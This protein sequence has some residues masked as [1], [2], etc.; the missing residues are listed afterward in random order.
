[1]TTTDSSN[2]GTPSAPT[3]PPPSD[4]DPSSLEGR[5]ERDDARIARYRKFAPFFL[6]FA[7]TVLASLSVANGYGDAGEYL[8]ALALTLV[9]GAWSLWMDTL[10]PIRKEQTGRIHVYYWVRWALSGVLVALNPW[11]A[12][13]AFLGY[14]DVRRFGVGRRTTLGTVG[15][16]ATAA[17]ITAAQMG[18]RTQLTVANVPLYLSLT[19]INT[20]VASAIVLVANAVQVQND[21]RKQVIDALAVTNARLETALR[22]NTGLHAQLLSQARE[23]GVLAERQRLAG[24]IHDTIAQGLA[25]IV[26][27]LGA[28]HEQARRHGGVPVDWQRHLDQARDLARDSLSEARRSVEALRPGLLADRVHLPEAI[29]ELVARWSESTGT[30]AA[31]GT[32][33]VV[34]TLPVD[35]EVALFRAAQEALANVAKHAHATRAG[36][37]LTYLD[38]VVLLDVRD[39]GVGPAGTDDVRPDGHGGY[40]LY[41]MRHRLARVGGTVTIEGAP[42]EG[43]T[44]NVSVP[45]GPPTGRG[46]LAHATDPAPAE[47]DSATRLPVDAPCGVLAQAAESVCAEP[48][49]A[50][51][52]PVDA[53]CGVLAQA[54]DSVCAEPDPTTRLPVDAPRTTLEETRA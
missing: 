19:A 24:E 12:V 14:V 20:I 17:V 13:F 26:T 49:S 22:E 42:G 46:A 10:R 8:A 5:T 38:D 1:M 33:G 37:S 29:A 45:T 40:G 2:A 35:C 18:G 52:L 28:A 34:R 9:A 48:D 41:A 50:T 54:A 39:D 6:L 25:G 51:R 27:Q 15:T 31:A 11:Y 7:S 36:V 44:V 32:D 4:L 16:V 30:P 43:T 23:A 3:T 21:Q 53:P 47:P